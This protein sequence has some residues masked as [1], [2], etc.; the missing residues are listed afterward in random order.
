MI[1]KWAKLLN[2]RK[3]TVHQAQRQGVSSDH[4]NGTKGRQEKGTMIRS[5]GGHDVSAKAVL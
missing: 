2:I 4:I 1:D 5:G 3:T